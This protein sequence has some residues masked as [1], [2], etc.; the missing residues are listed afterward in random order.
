MS[1][2]RSRRGWVLALVDC[3]FAALLSIVVLGAP[4]LDAPRLRNI[5]L[6]AS[7]K[8]DVPANPSSLI[9]VKPGEESARFA[10]HRDG[11]TAP[12]TSREGLVLQL[13]A[14]HEDGEPIPDV[15]PEPGARF[16]DAISGLDA[17]ASLW[18]AEVPR[19]VVQV[20]P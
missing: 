17:A 11:T 14:L 20:Q 7:E 19:L 13:Q 10:L 15:A 18:V 2:R 6:S 9:L 12:A 8:T 16:A 4:L 3:L 1:G 5:L